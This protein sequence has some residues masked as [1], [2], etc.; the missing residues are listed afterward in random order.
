MAHQLLLARRAAAEIF[1]RQASIMRRS[2][3]PA[4]SAGVRVMDSWSPAPP[5]GGGLATNP[6]S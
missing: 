5:G 1:L 3:A 4:S 6:F 2:L